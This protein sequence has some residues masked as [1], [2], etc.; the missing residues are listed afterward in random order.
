MSCKAAVRHAGNVA[1]VDLSGRLSLGEGSG[2]IRNTIK[3]IVSRGTRHILLNLGQVSYMDSAGLGELVGS[4]ASVTNAGGKIKLL[5]AQ[6]KVSEVLTI[7][8]LYTVFESF[9]DE[10]S[11][12]RSFGEAAGA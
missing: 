5:N 7:T 10:T 9:Q 12:L 3:D 4:Y 6:G 1:I 8:K 2:L 11:A